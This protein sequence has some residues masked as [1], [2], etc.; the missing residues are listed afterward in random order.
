MSIEEKNK[1]IEFKIGMIGP[2]GSGKTSLLLAIF[3]EVS[4]R[5]QN[6]GF[7][8]LPT[9]EGTN[10]AMNRCKST[11]RSSIDVANNSKDGMFVVPDLA[12][13][14]TT[15][16]YD[17]TLIIPTKKDGD[18]D[19]ESDGK[20]VQFSIK[21]YPGGLL[22]TTDFEEKI[23][24]FLNQSVTLLVPISADIA[25]TWQETRGKRNEMEKNSLAHMK[26]QIDNVV[27]NIVQWIRYKVENNMR[28]QLVF[29]PIK[30]EK[31]FNDNGGFLDKSKELRN[32]VIELYLEELETQLKE[33]YSIQKK[34]NE[35]T[36]DKKAIEKINELINCKVFSV[37]TYGIVELNSVVL[38]Y[39]QEQKPYELESLF[40][41][42]PQMGNAL[43]IKNAYELLIDIVGFQVN[44]YK[45]YQAQIANEKEM[46]LAA[47]L[48]GEG[49]TWP[50]FIKDVLFKKPK[51]E[52]SPQ[53][54]RQK[55]LEEMKKTIVEPLSNAVN[56]LKNGFEMMR[57]RQLKKSC[58]VEF[59]DS[60]DYDQE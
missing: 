1:P 55:A 18:D 28:A 57:N 47:Y 27:S 51:P 15:T 41:K 50:D 59:V 6:N 54:Q 3:D 40:N 20:S 5:V 49:R 9:D 7:K 39:D 16:D 29:V 44:E 58:I 35:K 31:Y 21:D 24:P 48:S 13:T 30:C 56:N 60:S 53:V 11:F 36:V 52:W 12:T 43:K 38:K 45:N 25:M 32:A 34:E 14:E 2:N 26:L 46:D 23:T 8:F 42:R 10:Q 22:G 37:D 19:G 4:K 17:F 33:I